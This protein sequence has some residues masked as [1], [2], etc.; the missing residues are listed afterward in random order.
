MKLFIYTAH[1]ATP[2]KGL[3]E[4]LGSFHKVI[5]SNHDEQI[6]LFNQHEGTQIKDLLP[7]GIID[8][9]EMVSYISP[10]DSSLFFIPEEM[11]ETFM[12]L[13]KNLFKKTK[14]TEE[15]PPHKPSKDEIGLVGNN[16][17]SDFYD[18]LET[19]T[20]LQ[21]VEDDTMS[22]KQELEDLFN[23]IA[24]DDNEIDAILVCT[25][26][27]T[28]IRIAYS[29]QPKEGSRQ[30]DVDSFT[31][32]I[33]HFVSMLKMTNKV[34]D[35]IGSLKTAE[36]LFSGGIVHITHLPQLGEYTFL[37]FVSATEE[38]IELLALHRKRNLDKIMTQLGE[39]LG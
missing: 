33:Q 21:S 15:E 38:G 22:K 10:D 23:A 34:N 4:P 6:K 37:V 25:S 39:M 1:E 18:D 9:D 27:E 5:L 36:L 31:V 30:V 2:F 7:E 20:V 3:F 29:S 26:D 14:W 17:L 11:Q 35:H 19:Q 12:K 28:K 24:Q 16:D 32:Q 8:P 13:L